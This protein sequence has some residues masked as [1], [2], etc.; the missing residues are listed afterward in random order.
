MSS[1]ANLRR[2]MVLPV[3][4]IR[5]GGQEKQLA[6]TLDLTEASA[7]L[8]GLASALEPGEAIEVQRGAV[9][10]KFQ[11]IWMGTPG[12]ALACQAGIRGLEPN[13]S[14][15]NID[16]PKDE[17]DVSVDARLRKTMPPVRNSAQFPG[18]RRWYPR[19][20]C[21]GS[22]TIKTADSAVTLRGEA[23]D[24]SNGGIYVEMNAPLPV[25]SKITLDL[26]VE[27]IR[28]EATG[29]VRTSYPLLGMGICFQ[30]VTQASAEKL[31]VALERAKRKSKQEQE[32]ASL[33][34]EA[35]GLSNSANA[36]GSSSDRRG[37]S[38]EDNP[39]PMLVKACR[40][41]TDDFDRWKGASSSRLFEELKAAIDELQKKLSSTV[42][43]E[44]L[45]PR[46]DLL[47]SSTTVELYDREFC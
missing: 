1:R 4:V 17:I 9:K 22:A 45:Q 33:E 39:T 31:A 29:L 13:K 10:A 37:L 34:A 24:I 18:E 35:Q 46:A 38:P 8:G 25:N 15:W 41:L 12:G 26:C 36:A 21:S 23:K 44:L 42:G 20:M 27:D 19:Y 7:R 5:H 14:I 28:F 47:Q 16:M 11:V 6:H 32:S 2:R 3:T 40:L 43:E 30:K